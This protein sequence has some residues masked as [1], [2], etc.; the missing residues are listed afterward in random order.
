MH[1]NRM[2]KTEYDDNLQN[3]TT[4][5]MPSLEGKN[6]LQSIMQT[7]VQHVSGFRLKQRQGGDGA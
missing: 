6:Q 2:L 5:K 4:F 1:E 3:Q 7:R